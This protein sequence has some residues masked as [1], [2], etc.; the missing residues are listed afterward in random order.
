MGQL[1][2]NITSFNPPTDFFVSKNDG[3]FSVYLFID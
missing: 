3:V 1:Q 2:D